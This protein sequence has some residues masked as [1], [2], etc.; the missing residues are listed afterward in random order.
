MEE[1]TVIGNVVATSC[2]PSLLG[3][4]LMIIEP[5][6]GSGAPSG[7]PLVAVDTTGSGPGSRVFFVRS[8]EAA[9]ALDDQFCPADA[10]IV[11][12]VDDSRRER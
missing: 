1:A 3:R 6:G 4:K 5:A 11:G 2:V 8:R 9:E 12:I 10:A 7:E